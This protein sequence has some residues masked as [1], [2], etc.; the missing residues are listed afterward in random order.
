[1]E[2]PHPQSNREKYWGLNKPTPVTSQTGYTRS[3]SY[4][5]LKAKGIYVFSYRNGK[6]YALS[7]VKP[8]PSYFWHRLEYLPESIKSYEVVIS[9]DK[10]EY[11]IVVA[12]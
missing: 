11:K 1:M 12:R 4:D 7:K 9:R 6:T 5:S 3:I 8:L 2:P 10:R